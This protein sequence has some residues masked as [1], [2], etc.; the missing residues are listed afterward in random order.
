MRRTAIIVGALVLVVLP[1]VLVVY[2]KWDVIEQAVFKTKFLAR[3]TQSP[4]YSAETKVPDY[5]V[6]VV[7]TAFLEYIAATMRL[8]DTNAIADPEMYFGNRATTKRHTVSHL[9]IELV[10]VLTRYMVGLGGS[11]DFAARGIYTVEEETL[12]VRVS[13]DEKELEKKQ[14]AC[15][16][17][18]GGHVFGYCA[19]DVGL[20]HRQTRRAAESVRTVHA[21]KSHR[22]KYSNWSV[23]APGEDRE[24]GR[25]V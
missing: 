17:C 23:S 19:P 13:I 15:K 9:R 3:K 10:P 24:D 4:Q 7:N 12:V 22:R 21:Q 25:I 1:L 8:Y 11:G 20:R 6:A 2:S 14:H 5:H 18:I 16:K